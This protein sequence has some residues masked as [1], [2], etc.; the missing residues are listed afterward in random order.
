ML[1]LLERRVTG[2]AVRLLSGLLR[3]N[4]TLQELDLGA[5]AHD[6]CI[7]VALLSALDTNTTLTNLNLVH[8]PALDAACQRELCAKAEE[9]GILQLNFDELRGR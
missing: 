9:R 5:T 4:G 6:A 2:P 1:S 7:P 3:N 8:N